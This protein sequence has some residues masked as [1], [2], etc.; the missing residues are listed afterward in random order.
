M[1]TPCARTARATMPTRW[2][3]A[4]VVPSAARHKYG[5][6]AGA[7]EHLYALCGPQCARVMEREVSWDALAAEAAHCL[8][9][10]V[11]GLALPPLAQ[12]IDRDRAAAPTAAFA[13]AL[14]ED[15]WITVPFYDLYV[16][17][18]V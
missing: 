3:G 16:C 6:D 11:C 2:A 12:A 1:A 13:D 4:C 14:A 7:C 9:A 15:G 8:R 10:P 17:D 5:D 18:N